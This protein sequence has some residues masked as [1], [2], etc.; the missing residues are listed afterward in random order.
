MGDA[1]EIADR[2]VMNDPWLKAGEIIRRWRGTEQSWTGLQNMIKDLI[3][4][5]RAALAQRAG[6][7][8]DDL[9]ELQ[10]TDLPA[11]AQA[12]INWLENVASGEGEE[13][14]EWVWPVAAKQTIAVLRKYAAPNPAPAADAVER[15]I[16]DV[17]RMGAQNPAYVGT[18]KKVDEA[19]DMLARLS[20]L[21]SGWRPIDS[22]P[23][24]WRPIETYSE[25][26]GLVLVSTIFRSDRSRW[27]YIAAREDG[28]WLRSGSAE[29]LT[30]RTVTHWQ[31]LPASPKEPNR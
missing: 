2:I 21:P 23:D 28:L 6:E 13:K 29:P 31:P 4:A 12:A 16:A 14:S 15:L 30:H 17:R 24:G 5:E 25:D 26:V 22:A 11:D 20:A 8:D 7:G 1:Q 18:W 10:P 19:L 27:T 3:E 9:I